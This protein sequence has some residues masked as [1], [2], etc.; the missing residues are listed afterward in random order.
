MNFNSHKNKNVAHKHLSEK[1]YLQNVHETTGMHAI[2][3]L[4]EGDGGVN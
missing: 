4:A 3:N 2:L 1:M